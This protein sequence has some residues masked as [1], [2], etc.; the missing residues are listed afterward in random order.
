MIKLVALIYVDHSP[1]NSVL[2][3]HFC[4]EWYSIL[5][6]HSH[7]YRALND[8]TWHITPEANDMLSCSY[9]DQGYTHSLVTYTYS[10]TFPHLALQLMPPSRASGFGRC[11]LTTSRNR[12][13]DLSLAPLW[14]PTMTPPCCLQMQAW[15]RYVWAWMSSQWHSNVNV[16]TGNIILCEVSLPHCNNLPL[17]PT[18]ASDFPKLKYQTIE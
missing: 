1:G 11:S 7:N 5:A 2:N 15:I 3:C 17:N 12:V 14:S 18:V 6:I 9:R 16:R 10:A 13:T 8:D 4:S